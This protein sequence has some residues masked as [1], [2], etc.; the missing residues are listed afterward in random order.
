MIKK[1]SPTLIICMCG[2]L[3]SASVLF[4][5]DAAAEKKRVPVGTRALLQAEHVAQQETREKLSALNMQEDG[6]P[7]EA[8]LPE[9]AH[10]EAGLPAAAA[11]S[12]GESAERVTNHAMFYTSHPGAFHRADYIS[13]FGDSIELEDGSIWSVRGSDAY[14]TLNW[15]PSDLIVITPNHS[16]FSVYN[17]RLTNQN[18]GVSVESNLNLGPIYNGPFTHWIVS[19]DYYHDVVYLEDGSVWNMS[20]Y[21]G[22]IVRKWVVNDTVIIGINDSW[23]SATRPNIL[24]NVNMLN[25]AAGVVAY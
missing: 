21:D 10:S 1:I 22:S 2:A 3:M 13:I 15:L 11:A 19:I 12:A 20:Y 8:V 7:A 23:L 25:Y 6:Q 18:T 17:F 24:I 9:R 16:W 5:Q 4:G 14:K